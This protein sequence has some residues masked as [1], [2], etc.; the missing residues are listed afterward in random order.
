L[1]G[2]RFV[3]AKSG[4]LNGPVAAYWSSLGLPLDT[5]EKNLQQCPVRI[6]ALDVQGE[7]QLGA[8]LNGLGVR[9]AER[10]PGLTVTLVNDY[11][12]DRLADLNRRHL[13]DGTPW[14]LV[15]SSGVFPLVGP[16]LR[17]GESACWRC[18]ADRM[19]RTREI[20]AMLGRSQAR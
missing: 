6:H 10:S 8:A 13:S 19:E 4:S 5:A 1:I 12:D 18:L 20:R 3:V 2:R 9:A 14:I 15:Q 17:P 16:V 11:L 7:Q